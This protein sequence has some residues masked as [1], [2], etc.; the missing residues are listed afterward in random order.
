MERVSVRITALSE[1]CRSSHKASR[2]SFRYTVLANLRGLR[3][4]SQQHPPLK[5]NRGVLSFYC[6]PAR[7]FRLVLVRLSRP[8]D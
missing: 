2:A 8:A 1:K 3:R 6:G 7:R 4:S 5:R